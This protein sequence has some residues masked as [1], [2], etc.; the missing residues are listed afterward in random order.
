MQPADGL[1]RLHGAA[2]LLAGGPVGLQAGLRGG[3]PGGGGGPRTRQSRPQGLPSCRSHL[4][5]YCSLGWLL[6]S[7]SV[8]TGIGFGLIYLP[9]ILAVAEHF[10]KQVTHKFQKDI[11]QPTVTV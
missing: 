10:T 4:I 3:R 6:A 5:L 7:Y 1:L 9:A 2:G 11:W 8:L